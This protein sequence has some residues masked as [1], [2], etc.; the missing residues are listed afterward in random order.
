MD[1]KFVYLTCQTT[2]R[3]LEKVYFVVF[4]TC[5]GLYDRDVS[6]YLDFFKQAHIYY[7]IL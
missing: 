4:A 1:I 7:F 2:M 6:Q 5:T 3:A